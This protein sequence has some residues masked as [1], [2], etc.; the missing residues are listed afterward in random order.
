[1]KNILWGSGVSLLL[2]VGTVAA[3]V[4]MIDRSIPW[5]LGLVV[6][7]FLFRLFFVIGVSV[8]VHFKTDLHL[9]SFFGGLLG[10]Y[11]LLQLLEVIYLQNRF[12][13]PKESVH[14]SIK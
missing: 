13:N 12:R 11:F 5:L 3:T 8:Y 14:E 10:S 2:I 6:G 4:K 9:L 1:M 7:G